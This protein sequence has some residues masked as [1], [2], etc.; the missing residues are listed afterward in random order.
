MIHS[1]E[2]SNKIN[3]S[4][5]KI[6]NSCMFMNWTDVNKWEHKIKRYDSKENEDK[7]GIKEVAHQHPISADSSALNL[8]GEKL[9]HIRSSG[10][11]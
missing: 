4:I 5:E 10:Q 11:L 2:R 3:T 7:Y 1:N 9:W 6:L 8:Q